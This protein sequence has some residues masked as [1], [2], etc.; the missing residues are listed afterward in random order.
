[1]RCKR[2]KIKKKD[3]ERIHEQSGKKRM[4]GKVSW[5]GWIWW[6]ERTAAEKRRFFTDENR[7]VSH[8][9]KEDLLIN[10]FHSFTSR[11][12]KMKLVIHRAKQTNQ[13]R[14]FLQINRRQ[15]LNLRHRSR[16]LHLRRTRTRW[17]SFAEYFCLV[18]ILIFESRSSTSVEFKNQGQLEGSLLRI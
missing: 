5:R 15:K 1:M 10:N 4:W 9:T 6:Q 17:L 11:L 12:M 3:R 14:H 8:W 13:R 7:Q 18:L 16:L 2:C